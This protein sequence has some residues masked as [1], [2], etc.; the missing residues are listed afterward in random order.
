MDPNVLFKCMMRDE[1]KRKI[2]ES[3]A[4]ESIMKKFFD[5]VRCLLVVCCLS[6][7]LSL[8]LSSF[9]VYVSLVFWLIVVDSF[10]FLFSLPPYTCKRAE[11]AQRDSFRALSFLIF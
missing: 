11:A 3:N 10:S 6:L 5:N 4:Y 7:L 8:F 9:A 1:E 2:K